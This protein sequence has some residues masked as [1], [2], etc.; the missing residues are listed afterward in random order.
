MARVAARPACRRGVVVPFTMPSRTDKEAKDTAK[1]LAKGAAR[2]LQIASPSP[3]AGT[4]LHQTPVKANAR[5]LGKIAIDT[6][7]APT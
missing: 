2:P 6:L 3:A 4:A 5:D 7:G 1:E